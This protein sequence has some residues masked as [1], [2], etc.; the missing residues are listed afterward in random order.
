[1]DSTRDDFALSRL[2]RVIEV[3]ALLALMA[4]GGVVL[5]H[6]FAL[7]DSIPVHFGL[8][9]SPDRYGSKHELWI[10]LGV[11]ALTYLTMAVPARAM[12]LA[13]RAKGQQWV[14]IYWPQMR[15]IRSLLLWFNAET[16][17]LFLALIH[18]TQ[19]VA[20]GRAAQLNPTPMFLMCGVMA[21][22]LVL[23]MGLCIPV[24]LRQVSAQKR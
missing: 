10:L 16:M 9:G 22:T 1:M 4:C 11:F 23:W 18:G 5:L 14:R 7:S 3:L 8:D 24:T 19:A 13:R 21:V 15:L 17:L 2:D 6:W 20:L 12:G